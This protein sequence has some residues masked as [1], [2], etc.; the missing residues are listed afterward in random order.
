MVKM[1]TIR[2]MEWFILPTGGA[3]SSGDAAKILA[4][5][6]IRGQKDCLFPRLDQTMVRGTA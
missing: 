2:G 4:R 5:P 6:D 3:V 1:N